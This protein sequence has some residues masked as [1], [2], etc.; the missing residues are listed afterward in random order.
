MC[1]EWARTHGKDVTAPSEDPVASVKGI[2]K[3]VVIGCDIDEG[4][5]TPFDISE[6]FAASGFKVSYSRVPLAREQVPH[7]RDLDLLKMCMEAASEA[8][9]V[10]YLI[11]SRTPHGSSTR[12]V[13]A[14]IACYLLQSPPGN[15]Y[16][17]D[18][19]IF[20]CSVFQFTIDQGE[21]NPNSSFVFDRQRSPVLGCS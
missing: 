4:I 17:L 7:T 11:L 1:A 8:N 13:A 12:F 6:G 9:N 14:F 16:Y 10:K 15:I 2:W 5:C 21:L 19:L 18:E 3:K 20:I